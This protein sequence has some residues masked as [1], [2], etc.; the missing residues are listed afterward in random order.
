MPPTAVRLLITAHT[1]KM[2]Q[3]KHDLTSVLFNPKSPGRLRKSDA[4]MHQTVEIAARILELCVIQKECEL[5]VSTTQR[6]LDRARDVLI[7]LIV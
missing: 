3:L 2:F 5:F 7:D 4:K 1:I 6:K